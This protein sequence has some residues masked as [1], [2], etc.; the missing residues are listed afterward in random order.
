MNLL[1]PSKEDRVYGFASQESPP[2]YNRTIIPQKLRP[3]FNCQV[4]IFRSLLT[5]DK[6]VDFLDL[7][8][9]L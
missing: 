4:K 6:E 9:H 2:L 1:F 7:C 8:R 3:Y 5:T